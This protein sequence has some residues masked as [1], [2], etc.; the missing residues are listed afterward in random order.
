MTLTELL[1]IKGRQVGALLR[2]QP[3]PPR[4]R[5][6]RRL[7]FFPYERF[8]RETAAFLA[9][10]GRVNRLF[11]DAFLAY[12]LVNS[13]LNAGLTVLLLFRLTDHQDQKVVRRRSPLVAFFL[14]VMIAQ[15]WIAIFAIHLLAVRLN[16]RVH[17]PSRRVLALMASDRLLGGAIVKGNAHNG[18]GGSGGGGCQLKLKLR[19]SSYLVLFHVKSGRRFGLTYSRITT[20][21]ISMMTFA[22]AC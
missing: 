4:R 12:L 6:F 20:L 9:E 1:S 14:G 13:P 18:G 19:L 22:E 17:A 15:S 8:L 3:A 21:R 2:R 7:H 10:V 16:G 5:L 11:A